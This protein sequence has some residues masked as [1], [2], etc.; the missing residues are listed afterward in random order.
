MKRIMVS[1]FGII[2]CLFSLAACDNRGLSTSSQGVT[3]CQTWEV[4]IVPTTSMISPGASIAIEPGWEP[5][6][7]QNYLPVLRRCIDK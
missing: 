7:I 3:S 5:F 4:K 2:G 6:S 1:I